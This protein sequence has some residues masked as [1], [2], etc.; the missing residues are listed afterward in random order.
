MRGARIFAVVVIL[1]FAPAGLSF[2]RG[3][4]HATA[5]NTPGWQLMTP[6]ERLEHQARVRGFTNYG[7]CL[8]YQ[9]SHRQLMEERATQ[10]NVALAGEGR[11]FCARL[12]AE[13]ASGKQ[14]QPDQ[15]SE[16]SN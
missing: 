13:D 4:W 12:K 3:P 16:R 15:D 8:A 14:E 6:Q 1:L 5:S 10:H 9:V 11:D 2:G 7:E